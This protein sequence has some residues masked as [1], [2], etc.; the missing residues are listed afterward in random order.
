[1]ITLS[2]R[3]DSGIGSTIDSPAALDAFVAEHEA[4][5]AP[6]L[7]RIPTGVYLQS[8]EFLSSNDIEMSGFVWQRY[9]PEIPES[10]T[11]G[12]V[13]P[14]QIEDAYNPVEAWRTEKDGAELIGWYFSGTFRQNFD[15]GLYPFDQQ[16]IWLRLWHPDDDVALVPD[17]DSY[18]DLS[19]RTMPG[20][21]TEVVY[22]GWDPIKSQFSY[23][24]LD[25]NVDF[26]LG[27]GFSGVPDP[28]FYFS[29]SLARDS[30]GPMLD[31]VILETV[32]AILL[33][34]LLVLMTHS[35]NHGEQAGLSVFDLV[36][37][38]GGLLFA[39]ILDRNSIRARIETQTVTY[40][41]LL[42]LILSGFIVLVVLG[43]VL[44]VKAGHF[45]ILGYNSDRFFVYAY[46]PAL[47]ASILIVTLRVFFF[48]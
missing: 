4:S 41:E 46:W 19:P 16:D 36:V 47:F 8:F 35:A 26:G 30:L 29:L 20:L 10:V 40:L 11:R 34:L 23:D 13:F 37:A 45:R 14:E 33:F 2:N 7:Y 3:W 18:R 5:F 25:Y 39:V 21:D 17:F 27:Y 15:Y 44:D 48:S 1:V 42:P 43:A 32:I 9:G 38:A 28:E 12:V 31:H 22:G 24:L 6:Y